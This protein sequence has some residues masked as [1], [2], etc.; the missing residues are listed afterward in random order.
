VADLVLQPI[1][2]AYARDR[3]VLRIISEVRE[4]FESHF[5]RTWFSLL[6]DGMPIDPRTMRSIRQMVG[7]KNVFPGEEWEIWQGIQELETFTAH[8]KRLLLPVLKERLG[9]S[10]LT[11]R[12]R[13]KDRRQYIIRKFVAFTFPYNLER[14]RILTAKLKECL[15]FY[16]PF[17]E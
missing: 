17:L 3:E 14:L 11:P 10:W 15:L 1:T 7:M 16:Y 8:L 4:V 2:E 6:I 5:D 9:I 12:Y 13:I